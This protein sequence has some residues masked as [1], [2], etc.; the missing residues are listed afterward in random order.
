[1]PV[2][3]LRREDFPA[4]DRFTYLNTASAGLVAASVVGPA[5]AFE[6]ELAQ[7]GT[8]GMDE[9]TEVGILE[10]ARNAAAGLLGADPASIAI[11]TSFTE[12][13]CQVAWWLRPGKNRNVVSTDADFP[14][15]TYP[16]HRIAEDTGCEVR[17][18]GLL[19]D[20]AGFDVSMI[21]DQ[22]DSAT[23]AICISHVQYL[24]GHLLD[25]TE[26]AALAH[27]NGALLIIDATQ[28]AG[29]I[30]IDVTASGADVVIAGSYKWL[31]ST[32]GAAICYLHPALLAEFRPPL[33][34]WR[35]TEHPYSLDARWLPLASTARRMEYSTMS[36]SAAIALGRAI[37]YLSG[38]SLA[39]VAAHNA[40]LAGQLADG[41]AGLGA[42]LLTPRDPARRAGTVAA[43]FPGRDGEA[44]AGELTR[45]GVIVSPRVGSTRF[46]MH[47][48]NSSDDVER[49]LAVLADV[50]R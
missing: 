32:F 28:S 10:D 6:A 50:L 24:T 21:A 49:A 2:P 1:M 22:V 9:D 30:P 27:D 14:S 23:A 34:G 4:F 5:H 39:E 3:G 43:R 44:V 48:Y 25:L 35:S 18:A 20:P 41:L 16:W 45:R 40:E 12:A 19:A 31:C 46:S 17:L 38:L 36:Y 47:F 13:L 11:G 15:V 8:T 26:L 42:T 33:A 37:R 29:Q 7:A